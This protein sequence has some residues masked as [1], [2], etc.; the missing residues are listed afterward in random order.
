MRNS[1]KGAI[2]ILVDRSDGEEDRRH[3]KRN[4]T[5]KLKWSNTVCVSFI[6]R[7]EARLNHRQR[8]TVKQVLRLIAIMILLSYVNSAIVVTKS[9]CHDT[10]GLVKLFNVYYKNSVLAWSPYSATRQ[11]SSSIP[12]TAARHRK[13]PRV[14]T[15]F[16]VLFRGS[17]CISPDL[18]ARVIPITTRHVFVAERTS[19]IG[20]ATFTKSVEKHTSIE[21]AVAIRRQLRR[22]AARVNRWKPTRDRTE[23]NRCL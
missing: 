12:D 5:A 3:G 6:R 9:I 7:S 17:S 22:R 8:F 21:Q 18:R 13:I 11:F 23:R 10:W 19:S 1:R 4:V 14:S 16:V 20:V 2:P 15:S